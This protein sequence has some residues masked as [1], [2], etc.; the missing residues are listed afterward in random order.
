[1]SK[2]F[3]FGRNIKLCY[4]LVHYPLPTSPNYSFIHLFQLVFRF[5][6]FPSSK[7][8][9]PVL[10]IC[11]R[12]RPTLGRIAPLW[13]PLFVPWFHHFCPLL[14]IWLVHGF[15]FLGCSGVYPPEA[16]ILSFICIFF[17]YKFIMLPLPRQYLLLPPL[18][19]FTIEGSYALLVQ[20]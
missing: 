5:A 8:R 15:L 2:T 16:W 10:V 3:R 6:Y 18:L 14:G 12:I 9:P 4:I 13:S 11:L 17:P 19:C 1:M 7:C 20:L